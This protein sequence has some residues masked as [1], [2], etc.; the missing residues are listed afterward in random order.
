MML[1]T[2]KLLNNYDIPKKTSKKRHEK[3]VVV[4]KAYGI[5]R[6]G[7]TIRGKAN[8]KFGG[9]YSLVKHNDSQDGNED[10]NQDVPDN[11]YDI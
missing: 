11:L 3:Y 2:R 10:G 7:I 6:K 8:G 9:V 5:C 1:G 4:I